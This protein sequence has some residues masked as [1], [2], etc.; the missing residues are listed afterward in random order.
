[1]AAA[2][3]AISSPEV[4]TVYLGSPVW[5][6]MNP[7]A[8]RLVDA[9]VLAG[10][11]VVP[12][13]THGVRA[14]PTSIETF[15]TRVAAKGGRVA[16]PLVFRFPPGVSREEMVARVRS[17]L[18]ARRDLGWNRDEAPLG[19]CTTVD[20]ARPSAP[21]CRV[22]AGL[23]WV[24]EPVP[25]PPGSSVFDRVPRLVR[26]GA[27]EL[28]RSEVTLGE[29]RQS[30][31]DGKAR[32]NADWGTTCAAIATGEE[33]VP[34]P[35]ISFREAAA[36][37]AT[38]GMRLPT[39]AEW[40]RAARGDRSWGWPWGDTFRFDG[41]TG[42]FGESA[43]SG[44]FESQCAGTGESFVTDGFPGLAPVCSFPAGD[45]ISGACDM[46]GNLYEWV[47]VEHGAGTPSPALAGGGW[48][49]C[50]PS[51]FRVDQAAVVSETMVYAGSGFRC[52]R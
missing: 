24:F 23:A 13:R 1:V 4:E 33:R 3:A 48:F 28:D 38:Y 5:G 29:F 7:V 12:F 45:A 42:N 10:K 37:C 40:T 30:V 9:S 27:F 41:K 8:E 44:R 36:W 16:A 19:A 20:P 6:T 14:D 35:C 26:V 32:A 49:D 47:V 31:R 34:M 17:D 50:E 11:Q 15:A 51:A 39:L 18:M 2:A 52:V 25:V 46:A 43:A 22:P 21:R